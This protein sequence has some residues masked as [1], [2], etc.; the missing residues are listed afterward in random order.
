MGK[1][2]LIMLVVGVVAYVITLVS[3]GKEEDAIG[4][5]CMASM[6][7]GYSIIQILIMVALLALAISFVAWIFD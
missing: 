6:G 1:I 2:L 3:G 7:C 4:Q 5:G